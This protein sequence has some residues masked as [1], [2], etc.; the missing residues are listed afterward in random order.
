MNRKKGK[1]F[2]AWQAQQPY[3]SFNRL[4]ISM[5]QSPAY[6]ALNKMQTDLLNWCMLW[7]YEASTR[8]KPNPTYYPKDKWT[9]DNRIRETDFFANI[10]KAKECGLVTSTQRETFYNARKWLVKLGFIDCLVDG[11]A[12]KARI[13]SVY[14]MSKRWQNITTADVKRL[15]QEER[16]ESMIKKLERKLKS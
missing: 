10:D 8:K 15:K 5:L 3:E 16:R 9:E 13:M 7:T 2:P 4:S 11:G 6:R 14:R 12:T 1:P